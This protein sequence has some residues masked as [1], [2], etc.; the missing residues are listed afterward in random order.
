MKKRYLTVIGGCAI[1]LGL[2][3]PAGVPAASKN[4]D[5]TQVTKDFV[6]ALTIVES[7]YAGEVKY[8]ELSKAAIFGMLHALDPHSHYY[9]REEYEAFQTDQQSQYFGIG[10]TIGERSSKVYVLAPFPNTPAFR[11]GVRYGDQ[12]VEIDG[13][14][15]AG[16]P[17]TK[18]ADTMKGPRGTKVSIKVLRPGVAEPIA[19]DIT[20]DAVP[21]PTVVNA[22]IVS[23][24]IGYI[25]LSRG[26]NLTTAQEVEDALVSLKTQGMKALVL[27]LRNNRGGLVF[28]A[29]QIANQFLYEGQ[30]V[31]TIRGRTNSMQNRDYTATNKAPNTNPLVVLVNPESAS[32]SEIVAGALQDHDRALV[33]GEQSFG[34]GLVQQPFELEKGNGGLILT[35]GKY[36]TPSGRLIQRDYSKLSIYDYYLNRGK[37]DVDKDAKVFQ[38]DLGRS[39]YGGGGITPDV[40]IAP[41]TER[42]RKTFR[43]YDAAFAF[44][45]EVVNGRVKGFEDFRVEQL[46]PGHSLTPNEFVVTDKYFDAFKKFLV[47]HAADFKV[48]A[49]EAD[50]EAGIVRE[51]LRNEL[52]T[53]HYGLETALQVTLGSDPQL[54]RAVSEL[55]QAQRMAENF[56]RH[57]LRVAGVEAAVTRS[58]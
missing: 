48:K 39:I 23:P 28:Q 20:R 26:F 37:H 4:I 25:Q 10:A 11:A 57:H 44:T 34:K 7:N 13:Q 27:D 50:A 19:L 22:Y 1:S 14:S 16:W 45:R 21:L 54:Q 3:L 6:E 55:P 47:A 33:V 29:V 15:T 40:T 36:Y 32:A 41:A 12:I 52:V 53:A 5:T 46:T 58:M 43:W 24:G 17:S 56:R 8:D 35:I 18:V 30:G 31:L 51:W 2:I 49:P 38:T 9:D 42:L